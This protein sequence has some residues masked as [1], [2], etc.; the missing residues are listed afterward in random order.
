MRL[1]DQPLQLPDLVAAPS[2]VAVGALVL[3]PD[4]P[5][6]TFEPPDRGRRGSEGNPVQG[7][8]K[9]GEEF[10]K[11]WC[12]DRARIFGAVAKRGSSI[13]EKRKELGSP[14]P[15]SGS[16]SGQE[17]GDAIVNA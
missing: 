17:K 5:S 10:V 7:V 4:I 12:R 2:T 13:L 14:S 9:F 8:H 16:G 1:R 6:Q 11:A 3:E 15:G